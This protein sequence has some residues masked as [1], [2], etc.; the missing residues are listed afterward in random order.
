MTYL[1]ATAR[2]VLAIADAAALRAVLTPEVRGG[3][4]AVVLTGA[5][6]RKLFVYST[7]STASDNG[8]TVLQPNDIAGANPGRW[9][10]L[11]DSSSVA[12]TYA[13]R[14]GNQHVFLAGVNGRMGINDAN[15][16][17]LHIAGSVT[18]FKFDQVSKSPGGGAGSTWTIEAQAG[19][20][21]SKGGDLILSVGK[22]GD[23]GID[24]PGF[25]KL[26]VGEPDL[27]G[28]TGTVRITSNDAP[29]M[30]WG[31][32]TDQ[33]LE[34]VFAVNGF[35]VSNTHRIWFAAGTDMVVSTADNQPLVITDELDVSGQPIAVLSLFA[36]RNG[37]FEHRVSGEP[38]EVSFN[39]Q[40]RASGAGVPW[41]IEAQRGASGQSGGNLNLKVG[42]AGT[43]GTGAPGAMILELGQPDAS[44]ASGALQ[45]QA[46]ANTFLRAQLLSN[47]AT[48]EA[49]GVNA[50]AFGVGVQQA[51]GTGAL[52]GRQAAF[53][54]G[55]GQAVAAGTNNNGGQVAIRSGG[56]GTGGS[57]G[58]HGNIVLGMHTEDT[59]TV[60]YDSTNGRSLRWEPSVTSPTIDQVAIA[61]ASA[62]GSTL[63]VRA[64][65]A[66]GATSNG[67]VASVEGGSGTARGG[68]VTLVGGS[69]TAGNAPGG[70][71]ELKGGTRSGTGAQGNIA[72]HTTN[73]NYEDGARITAWA[74]A[75][76][77]PTIV[78]SSGVIFMWVQNE[79]FKVLEN[80]GHLEEV[81][82][83]DENVSSTTTKEVLR[84]MGN[85]DTSST[86]PVYPVVIPNS[87][88]PSGSFSGVAYAR[89]ISLDPTDNTVFEGCRKAVV[90]RAG[91][92]VTVL[93]SAANQIVGV[94]ETGA[95]GSSDIRV[96]S[97][98]ANGIRVRYAS[99]K[100]ANGQS[101]SVWLDFYATEP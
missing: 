67:G 38:T 53:Y 48:F 59:L 31:V 87:G 16:F 73:P 83:T 101:V 90:R 36:R 47:V 5:L 11:G 54:A 18:E 49:D 9:L 84:R 76:R 62:T 80:T 69:G 46:N 24:Q 8:T 56:R 72:L 60:T 12:N 85:L 50:T 63:T 26:E 14:D 74:Q 79:Q 28:L 21:G 89:V 33:V 91:G 43:P 2:P 32:D 51:P 19:A 6:T 99:S 64:Q 3:Q 97:D 65:S 7:S 44:G 13:M 41:T 10:V 68:N 98:G 81:T 25:L 77:A 22:G 42:R 88:L 30:Q 78:P 92:T 66:T 93:T 70:H 29:F 82:Y 4:L 100:G 45:M 75:D 23:P 35:N 27:N 94:D 37:I 55:R 1:N 96:E 15:A 34:Q 71:I 58:A 52:A 39:Q 20:S 57:G 86:S 40:Q 95:A 17:N 61:G